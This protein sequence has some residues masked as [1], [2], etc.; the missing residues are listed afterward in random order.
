MAA[1]TFARKWYDPTFD[2]GQ[3]AIVGYWASFVGYRSELNKEKMKARLKASDPSQWNDEIRELRKN[4][5]ELT[6]IQAR[7]RQGDSQAYG[8][9]ESDKVRGELAA[10]KAQID[11]SGRA[12]A[13]RIDAAV[14][15]EE[16]QAEQRDRQSS[17]GAAAQTSTN[18]A[19]RAVDEATAND[20]GLPGSRPSEA[21]IRAA[22]NRI[23]A[24]LNAAYAQARVS[25]SSPEAYAIRQE[26]WNAS[27]GPSV[28]PDVR[29]IIKFYQFGGANPDTFMRDNYGPMTPAEEEAQRQRVLGAGGPS[30]R[31][32]GR[33]D[34]PATSAGGG[35]QG[36]GDPAR[37]TGTQFQQASDPSIQAIQDQIDSAKADLAN[38][39]QRRE[40]AYNN[41][42]SGQYWSATS[43]PL[44]APVYTR[45]HRN[46][47]TI[48]RLAVADPV[49][50]EELTTDLRSVGGDLR[51]LDDLAHRQPIEPGGARL[52]ANQTR[53][54]DDIPAHQAGGP[55]FEHYAS[56]LALAQQEMSDPRTH[57]QGLNRLGSLVE[58]AA[59]APPTMREHDPNFFA[60]LDQVWADSMAAMGGEPRDVQDA[61][62]GQP[63][64]SYTYRQHP[65]GQLELLTDGNGKPYPAPRAVVPNSEAARAITA[66]IGQHP[67]QGGSAGLP[68]S[69]G[70]LAKQAQQN[71]D[72]GDLHYGDVLS[73]E[74]SLAL[75]LPDNR[76]KIERLDELRGFADAT[77]GDVGGLL[78]TNYSFA[79]EQR[80]AAGDGA[81]LRRDMLL[82]RNKG[83]EGA[84]YVDDSRAAY[85]AMKDRTEAR[86]LAQGQ[87]LGTASTEG[88]PSSAT[89]P[90]H[91]REDSPPRA[92]TGTQYTERARGTQTDAVASMRRRV[93]VIDQ[94]IELADLVE[95]GASDAETDR[96]L[97]LIDSDDPDVKDY[98]RRGMTDE[99][100]GELAE[101]R[102]Q[103]Q[104]LINRSVPPGVPDPTAVRP[105][106]SEGQQANARERIQNIDGVLSS[107]MLNKRPISD[108]L[109][110]ALEKERMQLSRLLP[111]VE[112]APEP[113]FEPQ[114]SVPP[115]TLEQAPEENPVIVPRIP[116]LGSSDSNLIE[117]A[118]EP[119]ASD[120]VVLERL[121]AALDAIEAKTLANEAL[122]AI[123]INVL[124]TTLHLDDPD[125]SGRA[126]KLLALR[127]SSQDAELDEPEAP[128]ADQ[129]D[130]G[131]PPVAAVGAGG[132]TGEPAFNVGST[133]D[134]GQPRVH[135]YPPRN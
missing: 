59:N 106:T 13:A 27:Q 49:A 52:R 114:A 120:P 84:V 102:V 73:H 126:R 68:Q 81:G 30:Y 17:M 109:K 71:A 55:I 95:G 61:N 33:G 110:A 21:G 98:R 36:S 69:L 15:L 127:A 131:T 28:H 6:Q 75:A 24:A 19:R 7:I 85:D 50:V 93:E 117:Q 115:P 112:G 97:N 103:L 92:T 94:L 82:L 63:G 11:A 40:Q 119:P 129:P 65:D 3:P 133:G 124:T 18:T 20:L 86:Q 32:T 37:S 107:G 25:A 43:N 46:Q 54:Y 60:A 83:Q 51:R 77:P 1:I 12:S 90:E 31:G 74:I 111:G 80:L 35:G 38:L 88:V 104:R 89:E 16:L 2:V 22:R 125:I 4:I 23:Q 108:N 29:K 122:S 53:Q 123:E 66:Q 26:F 67:A 87:T 130:T 14:A 72:A 105:A 41:L 100:A 96:L 44:L 5:S 64:G 116:P 118:A 42:S 58:F 10:Q 39:Q 113:L 34:S 134:A 121:D 132:D 57:E 99:R 8:R 135:G 45:R 70:G 78:A 48:D 76:E 47:S 56:E 9:F 91:V 128:P 101:E 62:F 79:V